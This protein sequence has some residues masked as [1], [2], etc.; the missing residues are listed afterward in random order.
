MSVLLF[1]CDI[2]TASFLAALFFQASG[3]ALAENADPQCTLND[4]AEQLGRILAVGVSTVF[5]GMGPS[6][7]ISRLHQRDFVNVVPDSAE[8]YRRLRFWTFQD[9]VVYVLVFLVILFCMFFDLV[10]I[11]NVTTVDGMIWFQS[12]IMSI[13]QTVIFAPFLMTCLTLSVTMLS[14]SSSRVLEE[15]KIL[16]LC[17]DG[18]KISRFHRPPTSKWNSATGRD[19]L[20]KKNEQLEHTTGSGDAGSNAELVRLDSTASEVLEGSEASPEGI[21]SRMEQ[22]AKQLQGVRIQ[23]ASLRQQ[24]DLRLEEASRL[25]KQIS[26]M[27]RMEQIANQLQDVR[28]QQ[29][30]LQQ[31]A[32]LELE[33][34]S[35][36]GNEISSMT[37]EIAKNK[38]FNYSGPLMYI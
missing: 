17:D 13:A 10:F 35:R 25:G 22:I 4:P 8:W 3:G 21:Q 16:C 32:D 12:C 6:L 18:R 37:A 7:I 36:L 2:F 11:A 28:N 20:R 30:S 24:A 23:E 33:E 26:S 15:A 5:V 14:L 27:S 38:N 29:A 19:A 31:Q 1:V 34:A 9:R